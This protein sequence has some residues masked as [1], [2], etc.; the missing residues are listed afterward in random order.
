MIYRRIDSALMR[1][2]FVILTWN[3]KAFLERCISALV[4]SIGDF[5]DTE[6]IVM[7]NGSDDETHLYL[8]GYRNDARFKIFR[9]TKNGGLNSY[10]KLLRKAKGKFVV[11]VDDD[12]LS[13]PADIKEIFSSYLAEFPD[14]GY[15]ALDV[16][17]NEYTN[18]AKPPSDCYVDINLGGKIVQ[19][20]P[21]GG[22]CTCFRRKDYRKIKLMFD[23]KN[24]NMG[25]SEDGLLAGLFH[26][27][28]GLKSGIIK[29]KYCFHAS[30]PYYSKENGYL[31]RDIEK[32]KNSGLDSFVEAYEKF[33]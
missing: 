17:Q 4:E 11:V 22:W 33:K 2:S 5:D 10:K 31:D 12:V 18:G 3:R 27:W 7:D 15:L 20:G 23:L 19:L 13:F 32:Y 6:I 21:T 1:F 29:G 16:I 14:F 26:R 28:L 24:I 9:L 25:R 8:E 30:G